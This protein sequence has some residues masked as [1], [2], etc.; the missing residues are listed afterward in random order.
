MD[1]QM[2]RTAFYMVHEPTPAGVLSPY[3]PTVG[4]P[5]SASDLFRIESV[6]VTG[7]EGWNSC[8]TDVRT[9]AA[10]AKVIEGEVTSY[11]D[12]AAAESALQVLM[13]HDRVDILVP[14]FLLE[15]EE[16]SAYVRSEEP[17]SRLAFDLFAPLD[18]YDSIFAVEKVTA[19]DTVIVQ[20]SQQASMLVGRTVDDAKSNYLNLSPVQ[21][22]ALSTVPATMGAPAYFS[23]PTLT[24]FVERRGF[25][26]MLYRSIARDWAAAVSSVPDVEVKVDLPP[27]LAIILDRAP[28]RDSIPQAIA[29]LRAELEPVR[30]EMRGFGEIVK[31]ALTQREVERR[32][33]SIQA[34]FDAVLK[35]SREERGSV[36]LSLAKI[37]R[38]GV[39]KPLDTVIELLNPNYVPS[40]PRIL[41]NRTQTARLFSKLLAT[42]S[43][44]SLVSHVFTPSELRNLQASKISR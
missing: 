27:L 36:L 5:A 10:L 8:Y 1:L 26:G 20:S 24:N 4:Y 17:R 31:G 19:S 29:E 18:P 37:Y 23:D 33:R 38:A 35:V 39:K 34:S 43:M 7:H 28:T 40:D 32:C 41:V 3:I 42:D 44:H 21:V 6:V 15:R 11:A 9:C 22:A 14:G 2:N 25:F 12:L 13:W 16:F 30:L